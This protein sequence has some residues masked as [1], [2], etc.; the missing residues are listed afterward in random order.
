MDI[1]LPG[2][3]VSDIKNLVFDFNGT[4]TENC[5]LSDDGKDVLEKLSKDYKI[6]VATSD[7][8]G[9]AKDELNGLNVEIVTVK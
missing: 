4:L 1:K 8:F 3:G 9:N 5:K 7:T 2:R 6:Y